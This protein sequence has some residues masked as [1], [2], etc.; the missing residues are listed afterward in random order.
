MPE[1]MGKRRWFNYSFPFA[2]I[3]QSMD[4]NII[5]SPSTLHQSFKKEKKE[6]E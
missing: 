3:S 1:R 6:N 5:K 2:F 4:P